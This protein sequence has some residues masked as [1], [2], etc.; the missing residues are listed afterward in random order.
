MQQLKEY[1]DDSDEQIIMMVVIMNDERFAS[2][3]S[4]SINAVYS[5]LFLGKL[6]SSSCTLSGTR[7]LKI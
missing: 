7:G 1:H 4:C 5:R 3:L 2:V 6:A